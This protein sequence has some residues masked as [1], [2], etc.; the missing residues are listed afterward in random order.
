MIMCAVSGENVEILE[1]PKGSKPG[2]LISVKGYPRTPVRILKKYFRIEPDLKIDENKQAT[3]KGIPWTVMDK[4]VV[5]VPSLKNA[6][7][8]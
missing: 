6:S 1:P 5:V 2:D 4:G 7:I 3:Y 8:Y